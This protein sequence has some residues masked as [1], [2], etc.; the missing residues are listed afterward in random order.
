MTTGRNDSL[1]RS[2]VHL[3]ERS[4]LLL[5]LLLLLGYPFQIKDL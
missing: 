5:L 4:L 1:W 2:V 3:G